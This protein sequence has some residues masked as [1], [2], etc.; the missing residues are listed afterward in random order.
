MQKINLIL[1]FLILP[2]AVLYAQV[3]TLVIVKQSRI[4]YCL[5]K[6][7]QVQLITDRLEVKDAALVVLNKRI[8]QKD[9]TIKSLESSLLL[10]KDQQDILK[11]T[12]KIALQQN[13]NLSEE[14]KQLKKKVVV[15]KIGLVAI[16]ILLVLS[17]IQS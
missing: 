12:E 2:Q 3:D 1:L 4:N 9:L 10:S 5:S 7:D 14:N 16:T 8:D 6:I 13:Q 11:A 17:L 15:Q